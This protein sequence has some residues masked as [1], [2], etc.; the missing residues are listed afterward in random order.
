MKRFVAEQN[1]RY[2]KQ[3]LEN[4]NDPE[5][6]EVV[7]QLLAEARGELAALESIAPETDSDDAS[8]A[9][10]NAD[11]SGDRYGAPKGRG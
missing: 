2:F 7:T 11:H 9:N 1:I 3:I 10:D 5:R 4:E 6:R 8:K